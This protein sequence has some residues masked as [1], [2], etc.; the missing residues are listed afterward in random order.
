MRKT[1]ISTNAFNEALIANQEKLINLAEEIGKDT[2]LLMSLGKID[3]IQPDK[4]VLL[5]QYQQLCK[6]EDELRN[7]E[8]A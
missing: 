8:F 5:L 2:F 1:K 3:E 6:V 7:I 4:A